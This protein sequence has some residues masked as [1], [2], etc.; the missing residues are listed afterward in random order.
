MKPVLRNRFGLLLLV[1]MC[2][3]SNAHGQ[4][5]PAPDADQSG[6]E[7][8]KLV[9]ALI[10]Q[11]DSDDARVRVEAGLRL[12]ETATGRD[13]STI[14]QSVK[15]GNPPDKQKFLIRT[16]GALADPRATDALQFEMKFGK[17]ESVREAIYALGKIK[18]DWAVPALTQEVLDFAKT[19]DP[20][21]ILAAGALGSIGSLRALDALRDKINR[22]SGAIRIAIAWALEVGGKKIDPTVIDKELPEGQTLTKLYKGQRYYFYHPSGRRRNDPKPDLFVCIHDQD[23]DAEKLFATC[24]TMAKKHGFAVLV[25]FFDPITF[26]RYSDFNLGFERSD[27]RLLELAEHVGK[28]GDVKSHELYLWGTGI[29]GGFVQRFVMVHPERVA[30]AAIVN[31]NLNL[32]EP[33]VLFPEGLGQT[34]LAPDIA[35]DMY[36]FVKSDLSVSSLNDASSAAKADL[37]K[38]F[39]RIFAYENQAQV[40]GR[41]GTAD[42]I[43]TRSS[44]EL[45]EKHIFTL[46][47][48]LD[49]MEEQR[50]LKKINLEDWH[51]SE[52]R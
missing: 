27:S 45:V 46:P 11:L 26:P 5:T 19:D 22:A 18:S 17:P 13:V 50:K 7:R 40:R 34:P 43:T 3:L 47:Y 52:G 29:G 15:Q 31:A 23:M 2:M 44:T 28:F 35:I 42:D 24:V 21:G 30:R 9:D 33:E 8:V 20:R 12:Q 1:L 41:I 37:A 10:R 25:P 4:E 16:L 39:E 38:F 36:K 32:L 6:S 14:A 48:S 51:R 49:I